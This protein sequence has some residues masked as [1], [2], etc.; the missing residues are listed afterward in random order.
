MKKVANESWSAVDGTSSNFDGIYLNVCGALRPSTVTSDCPSDNAACIISGNSKIGL[1]KFE[2][3]LVN[4]V[5]NSV[6]LVYTNGTFCD[7]TNRKRRKSIITFVCHP[8]QL[9]TSPT[10]I[11]KSQDDCQYEF[12]WKTGN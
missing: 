11:S 4:D 2:T 7:L 9:S 10:L 6:Q 8:G 1:G 3:G 5:E 12:V